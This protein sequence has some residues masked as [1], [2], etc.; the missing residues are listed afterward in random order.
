MLAARD[1]TWFLALPPG[2]TLC[3]MTVPESVLGG[4]GHGA[5]GALDFNVCDYK[6]TIIR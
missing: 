3:F 5:C 2:P 1:F 6:L 4:G